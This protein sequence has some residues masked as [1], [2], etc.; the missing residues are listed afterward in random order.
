M[1]VM[2]NTDDAAAFHAHI[3]D[4]IEAASVR[5]DPFPH[6]YIE[7]IFPARLHE[8]ME[9]YMPGQRYC[10]V[11]RGLRDA[12]GRAPDVHFDFHMPTHAM[13]GLRRHAKLWKRNFAPYFALVDQLTTQKLSSLIDRYFTCLTEIGCTVSADSLREGQVLFCHRIDGWTIGPYTQQVS[14][15]IQNTIYFAPVR[16]IPERGVI[17]HA[18]NSSIQI[19]TERFKS[20]RTV[21]SLYLHNVEILPYRENLLISILNTPFSIRSEQVE[22]FDIRCAISNLICDI[23]SPTIPRDVAPSSFISLVN[24]GGAR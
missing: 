8:A 24:G 13:L 22:G 3:R 16:H 20:S 7:D 21:G 10:R 17:L 4:R 6:L 9:R 12:A 14:Q 19:S 11:I 2:T 23:E 15:V 18:P 1:T 5:L